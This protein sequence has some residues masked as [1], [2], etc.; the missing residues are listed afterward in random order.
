MTKQR[1]RLTPQQ[2][3]TLSAWARTACKRMQGATWGQVANVATRELGFA[4][5]AG[6]VRGLEIDWGRRRGRPR[7]SPNYALIIEQIREDV[8]RIK[9]QLAGM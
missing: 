1:N 7:T 8:R 9:A 4:I 3:E 5:T 2:L 6:N